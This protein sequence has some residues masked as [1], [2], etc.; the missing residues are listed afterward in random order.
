M[1]NSEFKYVTNFWNCDLL[2][3]LNLL[4]TFNWIVVKQ[5]QQHL[6]VKS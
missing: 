3:I 5:R 4:L 6:F 2:G 1:T